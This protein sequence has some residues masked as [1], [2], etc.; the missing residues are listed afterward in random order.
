MAI[1]TAIEKRVLREGRSWGASA[2]AGAEGEGPLPTHVS[3]RPPTIA[4]RWRPDSYGTVVGIMPGPAESRKYEGQVEGRPRQRPARS[5][6][7][8]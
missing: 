4:S 1:A 2:M 7:A 8:T 3:A 6:R 5:L